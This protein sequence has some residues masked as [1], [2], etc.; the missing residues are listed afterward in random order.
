MLPALRE[1]KSRL[2]FR[3]HPHDIRIM[4]QQACDDAI[5]SLLCTEQQG[6]VPIIRHRIDDCAF[7]QQ[8][9]TERD[10][11]VAGGIVER[12]EAPR[13]HAFEFRSSLQQEGDDC[14]V[15]GNTYCQR[16]RSEPAVARLVDIGSFV[17][18]LLYT[19]EITANACFVE[20]GEPVHQLRAAV[21]EHQRHRHVA[22]ACGRQKRGAPSLLH[23]FQVCPGR[24]QHLR[25]LRMRTSCRGYK[26]RPVIDH[27]GI[28]VGTVLKEKRYDLLVSIHCRHVKCRLAII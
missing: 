27:Q 16:Q 28:H 19:S 24:E 2:V 11:A 26:W 18:K 20:S 15:A 8:E 12:C 9:L 3:S 17:Q 1:G 22:G 7:L 13:V 5:V 4:L 10:V 21:K 6:S 14:F 25:D 23:R